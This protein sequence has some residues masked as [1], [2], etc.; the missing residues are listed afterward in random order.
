MAHLEG[1]GYTYH[2]RDSG[3]VLGAH[4]LEVCPSITEDVPSAEIHPLSIGGKA[5]PVR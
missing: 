1:F 2:L 4:M 3:K 5:G